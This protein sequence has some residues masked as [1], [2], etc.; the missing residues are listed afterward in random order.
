MSTST[1]ETLLLVEDRSSDAEIIERMLVERHSESAIGNERSICVDTV[2]HVDTLSK[3]IERVEDGDISV[4][5]LD[6]GLPDS[7]GLGTVSTMLEHTSTV[8]VI[9]LTGQKG[10]GVEAIKCGAQDYLLKGRLNVD[11]LVRTISYAIERARILQDQRDRTHQLE[12]INEILRTELRDDMSM[13]VGH[14]DGLRERVE[15]DQTT[16]E[17]ILE[18]SNHAL[19]VTDTVAAAIDVIT[20][21]PRTAPRPVPIRR[22]L[23][24]EL[25]RFRAETDTELVVEWCPTDD[26]I[27]VMSIPTLGIVFQQILQNAVHND[28]TDA[29]DVMV[30]LT[31]EC[32]EDHVSI[33]I[34]DDGGGMSD[35]RK[36]QLTSS[37][38]V[39]DAQ[40][41]TNAV[42]YLVQTVL[43]RV[44][45]DL[46]IADND[47]QGTVVTIR[48]DRVAAP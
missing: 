31:V 12:R 37:A 35:A 8:P 18:A 16:V 41:R 33:A 44:N 43:Q 15:D 13:I 14:A 48:L 36:Q 30:T 7:D 17:A 22:V 28:D 21:G 5:L 38:A 40:D 26:D 11:T 4:V 42:W 10:M 24:A 45:G 27:T 19:E 20:E 34:A 29:A 2:E 23:D 46:S 1:G 25:E 9:V 39:T 47:P 6:L 32:S 3:A